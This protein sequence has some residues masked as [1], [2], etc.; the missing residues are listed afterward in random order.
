MGVSGEDAELWV[1]HR[2]EDASDSSRL[3]LSVPIR[4]RVPW[5]P[6]EVSW[7]AVGVGVGAIQN[8]RGQHE[9]AGGRPDRFGRRLNASGGLEYAVG[10]G[11]VGALLGKLRRIKPGSGGARP[12]RPPAPAGNSLARSLLPDGALDDYLRHSTANARHS[13]RAMMTP[14]SE[15]FENLSG[16]A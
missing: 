10:P 8:G 11:D 9:R 14:K 4:G 16:G 2:L 7:L 6:H 15:F 3:A 13:S 12:P 1:M 5:S